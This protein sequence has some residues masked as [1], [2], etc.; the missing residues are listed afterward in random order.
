MSIL[1][2][3]QS[4]RWMSLGN[5]LGR[6]IEEGF[7]LPRAM[8]NNKFGDGSIQATNANTRKDQ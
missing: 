8:Q 1:D 5:T 6:L 4:D 2:T 7:S 3:E